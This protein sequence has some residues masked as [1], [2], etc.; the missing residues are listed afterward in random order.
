LIAST[1]FLDTITNILIVIFTMA[2][3]MYFIF[4][5]QLN[6]PDHI[7]NPIRNLARLALSISLGY[8]LGNTFITRFAFVLDRLQYVL[9]TVLGL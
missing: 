9:I 1:G 7:S 3:V 2:T 8:Y 4:D 5:K 6:P